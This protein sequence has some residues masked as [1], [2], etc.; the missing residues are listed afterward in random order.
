MRQLLNVT[1]IAKPFGKHNGEWTGY[2]V[3]N[4]L[5]YPLASGSL[6]GLKAW[7]ARE[8]FDGILIGGPSVPWAPISIG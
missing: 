1:S 2:I 3:E 8:G 5:A 7:A 4:G 6:A